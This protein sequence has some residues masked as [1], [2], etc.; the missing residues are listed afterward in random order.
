M[1]NFPARKMR[2]ADLPT[3]T[4]AVR[5]QNERSFSRANQYSYFAHAL[6]R[7]SVHKVALPERDHF[8]L[9]VKSSG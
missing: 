3:L 4:L 7:F 1:I 9:M 6:C 5:C 2:V 8:Y